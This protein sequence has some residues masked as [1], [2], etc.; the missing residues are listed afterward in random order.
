M[1]SSPAHNDNAEKLEGEEYAVQTLYEGRPKCSCCKN[2]VEDF[3]KDLHVKIESQPEVKRKALVVRMRRNHDGGEGDGEP[4]ALDSIVVQSSSLKA[5]LSELFEG[6]EGITPSLKK[7]VFRS[8]FRPFYY[9]WKHFGHILDRQKRHDPTAAT[10]TQL[11]YNILSNNFGSTIAEIDDHASH[12]VITH[13][14][15]WALFE[16]GTRVIAK[17]GH[18]ERFFIVDGFSYQSATGSAGVQVKFIDWNGDRFGYAKG[19][20]SIP[21]YLGTHAINKLSVYPA[22]F[23]E[24]EQAAEVR[25]ISRGHQFESLCGFHHKA[26]SGIARIKGRMTR[27]RHG[28][29]EE[30]APL[31]ESLTPK[32]RV[33]DD[34]HDRGIPSYSARRTQSTSDGRDEDGKQRRKIEV[35]NS[36]LPAEQKLE[37]AR[38]LDD[39]QLL[40]C[41]THV[42]GY[43]LKLKRWAEF[44]VN[45]ITEVAYNEFAF[46]NLMLPSGYK[47]LILSFVEGQTKKG[48]TFD[49]IIEGKGQASSCC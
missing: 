10:Y 35:E 49:D 15:L 26:Y 16:P 27:S 17:E 29:R 39:A 43:S 41:N 30:L 18:D 14:Q 7:V 44:R 9:R 32:I 8:P 22:Q 4:L 5:T 13:S 40:L 34:V 47:N 19:F 28:S 1:S 3:P 23:H 12:G 20:I 45:D 46:P 24:F 37:F 25:A 6:Y 31:T 42:K 38:E 2:W 21:P 33:Q 48:K 11:L 36:S